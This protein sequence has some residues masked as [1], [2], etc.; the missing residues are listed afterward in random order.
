MQRI[1]D[2]VV[3]IIRGDAEGKW[4]QGAR[5][6]LFCL[7]KVYEA[8]VRFRL[9]MFRQRLFRRAILGCPVISVGNITVGGTGKTPVVEMLGRALSQGGRKVAI[10]SRGYKKRRRFFRASKLTGLVSDGKKIEMN[11]KE[12]GDEPYMLARNL[13]GVSVLV[14]KNRVR[15]GTLAIQKLGVDVL[16]LDDGFQYLPIQKTHEI[17]LID[18]TNPFGYGHPLPRG[19]LREPVEE[20][21]R[22]NFIFLTKAEKV[23][24]TAFIRNEIKKV[25]PHSEILECMHDPKYL[26]DLRTEEKIPLEFL[27]SKKIGALSAIAIPEGFEDTLRR[28]SA[29][30]VISSRFRDHHRY[31]RRE[32]KEVLAEAKSRGVDTIVTTEK[33]AVRIPSFHLDGIRMLFLRVEIK[34]IKGA[35][36]F[37]DFVHNICYY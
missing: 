9:W 18:C 11:S 35:A 21:S 27:K 26:V 13:D 29:E 12:A 3:R 8:G 25:A 19:L 36:D 7:S 33:D 20:L 16:L 1:E 30:I 31:R 37:N 14:D 28:L 2:K 32:L 23:S 17:L 15:S 34:I 6:F 24:D 22:A 5:G 4:A 10:L